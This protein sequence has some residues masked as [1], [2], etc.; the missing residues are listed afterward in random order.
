MDSKIIYQKFLDWL[1]K[2]NLNLIQFL[3]Y[4]VI[5]IFAGFKIAN[6]FSDKSYVTRDFLIT[7]GKL[8]EYS[9][10]GIGPNRYLTYSYIVNGKTF[11][12]E[13]NGPIKNY[14][15]CAENISLCEKKRFFV[16]YSKK[17][18]E[19]SLIDVT[20][21]IQGIKDPLFPNDLSNFQ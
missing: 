1:K 4:L 18:P 14:D 21:E 16:I 19:K 11:K 13:I 6:Y 2:Y 15:E 17:R 9:E 10:F 5:F 12:R 7:E 3:I 8:L 20:F